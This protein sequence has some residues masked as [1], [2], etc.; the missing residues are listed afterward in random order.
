MKIERHPEMLCKVV[1]FL[2]PENT[3]LELSLPC[4]DSGAVVS[5]ST[6]GILDLLLAQR[7]DELILA[8]QFSTYPE[9]LNLAG[10]CRE[11][12]I[13]VGLVPQPYELY[14]SRPHLLDLDG[15]PILHF[16]AP[17]TSAIFGLC[18]RS[19]DILLSVSLM[20]LTAPIIVFLAVW[21]DWRTGRAFRRE[22]RCGLH[23][24]IFS[25][26]RLNIDRPPAGDSRLEVMLD[27]LSFTEL[28]QLWNVLRGEM[29]LVG[30][31]PEAPDRV[32][33]YSDWQRQRL[34]VKPGI[35]GLAQVHGVRE[36]HSSEEKTRFDLQYMLN[37][38]LS[39]DISLILQTCWTVAIR[40]IR[41]FKH[42]RSKH[43][44]FSQPVV[45][46]AGQFF[47]DKFTDAHSTQSSAD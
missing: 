19:V 20:L 3:P 18:K 47:E 2:Q 26:M 39:N 13:T 25:M 14:L 33:C 38:S 35:T 45:L 6:L 31:R 27:R 12:G 24:R 43:G 22:T 1:G 10:R 41:P 42:V 46:P 34:S 36:L 28:P 7:V 32:Q 40:L 4:Q 37:P 5:V 44:D 8:L 30:P 17:S 23:G 11:L 21:L 29:S 9:V 15:L 16:Q